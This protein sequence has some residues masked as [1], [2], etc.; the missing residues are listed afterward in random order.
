MGEVSVLFPEGINRLDDLPWTLHT[1]IT[2]A[3]FYLGFEELDPEERP[4]RR[5]WNRPDEMAAW[6]QMVKRKRKEKY[7]GDDNDGGGGKEEANAAVKDMIV[8]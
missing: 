6:W 1:A 4:A 7:G 2:Q 3:L 8:G 5:I